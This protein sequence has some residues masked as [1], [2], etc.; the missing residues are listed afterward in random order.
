IQSYSQKQLSDVGVKTE[1][2]KRFIEQPIT[3]KLE[4]IKFQL[5]ETATKL[6]NA[7]IQVIRKKEIEQEIENFNLE[8]R[9]LNNQAENIR[10]SL[11]GVSSGDQETINKKQKFE[12]RSEERRVG[13]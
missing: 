2:L 1:E 4:K 13:S 10:K 5:S 3:N 11:K 6:K 12:K 9:S 7:Y 8:S